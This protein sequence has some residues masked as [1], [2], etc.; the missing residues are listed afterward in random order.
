MSDKYTWDN[1]G[2][3][4]ACSH[5]PGTTHIVVMI[6]SVHLSEEILAT[7]KKISVT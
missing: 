7:D 5:D 4:R 3:L 1:A 2:D 6:A